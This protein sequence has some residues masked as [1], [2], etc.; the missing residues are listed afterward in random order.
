MIRPDL[1]PENGSAMSAISFSREK[2]VN[3]GTVIRSLVEPT[4]DLG[5]KAMKQ[6][7]R[8]SYSVLEPE[9]SLSSNFLL[10]KL[11]PC[12]RRPLTFRV[13][14]LVV[15]LFLSKVVTRASSSTDT[16]CF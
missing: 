5:M 13:A 11:Q 10:L 3:K 8:I 6:T 2:F 4:S 9:P 1:L 16:F 14:D 15:K 7:G 12:N